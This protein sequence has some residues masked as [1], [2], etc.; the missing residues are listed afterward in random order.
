M[1]D[2]YEL[3]GGPLD[4]LTGYLGG[5]ADYLCFSKVYVAAGTHETRLLS[6]Y[7]LRGEAT[8]TRR[9]CRP[10]VWAPSQQTDEPYSL[11]L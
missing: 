4:G 3:I 7:Y 5:D 10:Y 1:K 8:R 6:N 11:E 9:D 2:R